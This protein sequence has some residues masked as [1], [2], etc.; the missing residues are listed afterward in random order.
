MNKKQ[1]ILLLENFALFTA[2]QKELPR[3]NKQG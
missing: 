1:A 3:Q 2:P